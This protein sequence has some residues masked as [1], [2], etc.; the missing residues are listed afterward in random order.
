MEEFFVHLGDSSRNQDRVA[1]GNPRNVH[2]PHSERDLAR[3]I[4]QR[5]NHRM[6]QWFFFP[7]DEKSHDTGGCAT[8]ASSK[9]R[10][11]VSDSVTNRAT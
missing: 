10:E 2:N 11:K 5:N 9:I 8:F 4:T 1:V 7:H 6:H 3:Q